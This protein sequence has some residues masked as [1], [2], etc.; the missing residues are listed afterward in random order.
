MTSLDKPLGLRVQYRSVEQ[1]NAEN[2]AFKQFLTLFE[3]DKNRLYS[4]IHVFVGRSHAADDVFQET[5]L[6]LWKEFANFEIG[7]S[8][9]KWANGI[10][11]RRVLAFRRQNKKYALGMSDEFLEEF[12]F[13]MVESETR[14]T[15]QET[16]LAYLEH[17]RAL[18]S[19]PLQQIY[20]YFYIQN[21]NAQEVANHTGRSIHAIRKAVHKMRQKIFDCVDAKEQEEPV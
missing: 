3:A 18:L 19:V 16:K 14:S 1:K 5:C 15:H 10:A 7:T 8:F 9:S 12:Y 21:F 2:I 11:F 4:Y 6:T 17:C 20:E 13:S